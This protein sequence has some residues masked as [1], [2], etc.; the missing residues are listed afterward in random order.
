M[1]HTSWIVVSGSLWLAIGVFLL[2]MGLKKIVLGTEGEQTALL[3]ISVGLLIGF[4]KGR[5][6]LSKTVDRVCHRILSQ[7]SPVALKQVYGKGYLFLIAGMMALGMILKW[8][9]IPVH[10]VGL[11]DVAVGSALINGAFL[12]YRKAATVRA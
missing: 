6:V 12:Y 9:P 1:K 11:V 10:W 7:P 2:T 4:F 3:L 8:V 5:F